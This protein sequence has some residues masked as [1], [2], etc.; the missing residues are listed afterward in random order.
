L[1]GEE[2]REAEGLR[3]VLFLKLYKKWAGR[4]GGEGG[5]GGQREYR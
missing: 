4:A 2:K 3:R 5:G 1:G